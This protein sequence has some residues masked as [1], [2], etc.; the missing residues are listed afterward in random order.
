MK[1]RWYQQRTQGGS[2]MT[3]LRNSAPSVGTLATSQAPKISVH[4]IVSWRVS[5]AGSVVF[6][7]EQFPS[8]PAALLFD[9]L[10]VLAS[11]RFNIF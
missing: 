3:S 5:A 1:M 9:R 10:G 8:I 7:D 6:I 4:A 11:W 2:F